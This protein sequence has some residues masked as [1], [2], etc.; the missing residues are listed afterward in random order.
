ME[1]HQCI[2]SKEFLPQASSGSKI[3][4]F[5]LAIRNIVFGWQGV[6][7]LALAAFKGVSLWLVLWWHHPG[8]A[9]SE[10]IMYRRADI[11]L[12]QLFGA[13]SRFIF[14]EFQEIDKVGIGFF[15]HSLKGQPFG[16]AYAIFGIFGFV[17]LD[18]FFTMGYYTAI[19]SFLRWNGV[20]V[21]ASRTIGLTVV[22]IEA[23]MAK[24]FD[25]VLHFSFSPLNFWTLRIPNECSGEF[26][27]LI[28][29][30]LASRVWI[31]KPGEQKWDWIAISFLGMFLLYAQPFDFDIIALLV[32]IIWARRLIKFGSTEKIWGEIALVCMLAGILI[33]PFIVSTVG[34]SP[35]TSR[36]YGFFPISRA[37]PLFIP[38]GWMLLLFLGVYQLFKR[39]AW[40]RETESEQSDTPGM[41][42]LN[43]ASL[44]AWATLPISCIILGKT[45]QTYHFFQ[46][47]EHT[48]TLNWLL[49]F[50][51][52]MTA[53]F[54]K[55]KKWFPPAKIRILITLLALVS[56]P[57]FSWCVNDYDYHRRQHRSGYYDPGI[58]TY[59]ND[60]FDMARF[61][62]SNLSDKI[63][64]LGTFDM[65]IHNWWLLTVRRYV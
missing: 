37:H 48:I 19:A 3:D 43:A 47:F 21:L 27:Y 34:M 44:S 32:G 52:C 58:P 30:I 12:F 53:L 36:R 57:V 23:V 16:L 39:F 50:G 5:S 13:A 24:F 64:V 26:V 17:L 29:L 25:Q 62:K 4:S 40:F 7:F 6:I 18:I 56:V 46:S 15:A 41:A 22:T 31:G 38:Q 61:V 51:L 10:L 14:S 33:V 1:A 9:L 59:R 11:G 49:F 8:E 54:N 60:F 28:V 63:Q 2:Q 65:A 42:F 35:D 45:S 55:L 20:S